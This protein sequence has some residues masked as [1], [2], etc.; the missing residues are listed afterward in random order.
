MQSVLCV[1]LVP[2][3]VAAVP[4]SVASFLLLHACRSVCFCVR[5]LAS[6]CNH[7]SIARGYFVRLCRMLGSWCDSGC[8][9]PSLS[10]CGWPMSPSLSRSPSASLFM[11]EKCVLTACAW[12]Y[13][14][15]LAHTLIHTSAGF[16]RRRLRVCGDCR[17]H[18]SHATRHQYVHHSPRDLGHDARFLPCPRSC[19]RASFLSSAPLFP[20]ISLSHFLSPPVCHSFGLHTGVS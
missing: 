16:D 2:W 10:W 5:V 9:F 14:Y 17:Y 3:P 15:K 7:Y 18:S 19:D 6:E 4:P 20:P 11:G 12:K 1:H 8:L 13:L